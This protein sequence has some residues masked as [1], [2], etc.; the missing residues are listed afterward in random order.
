MTQGHVLTVSDPGFPQGAYGVRLTDA[1]ANEIADKV[2][3]SLMV[4]RPLPETN[5][6][7]WKRTD[8]ELQACW[9]S[10]FF[11]V[12]GTT[13]YRVALGLFYSGLVSGSSV[14]DSVA[15]VG[16]LFKAH[17]FAYWTAVFLLGA[18]FRDNKGL[19]PDSGHCRNVYIFAISPRVI[20]LA[21]GTWVVAVPLLHFPYLSPRSQPAMLCR[22]D[23]AVGSDYSRSNSILI[24]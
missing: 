10:Q 4:C 8:K 16:N 13:C 7:T 17:C 22:A 21:L 15:V 6:R 14:G 20:T 12:T 3:T 23:R 2:K 9:I 11:W 18:N 5:T 19:N 24:P 1:V